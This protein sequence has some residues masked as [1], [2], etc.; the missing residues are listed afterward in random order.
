MQEVHFSTTNGERTG[1]ASKFFHN[2]GS[3]ESK[4]R[5]QNDKAVLMEIKTRYQVG[6]CGTEGIEGKDIS[7]D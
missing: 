7:K 4:V 6:T 3:A 1:R 5:M 2:K